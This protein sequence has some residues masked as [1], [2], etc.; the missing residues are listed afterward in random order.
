MAVLRINFGQ[1]SG[2][3]DT[4]DNVFALRVFQVLAINPTLSA[5][6]ITGKGDPCSRTLASIA[7]HHRLHDDGRTEVIAQAVH[8]AIGAGTLS[9]PTLKYPFDR[10]MQLFIRRYRKTAVTLFL[11]QSHQ[12]CVQR[13]EIGS[14]HIRQ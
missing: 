9:G 11:S 13:D 2:C 3:P 7:E 5:G 4:R 6:G 12:G 10:D 8:G 14:I 1:R